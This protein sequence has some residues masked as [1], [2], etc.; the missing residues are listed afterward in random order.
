MRSSPDTGKRGLRSDVTPPAGSSFGRPCPPAVLDRRAL[1]LHEEGALADLPERPRRRWGSSSASVSVR[2]SSSRAWGS[3]SRGC[4]YDLGLGVGEQPFGEAVLAAS[5][6]TGG[7]QVGEAVQD[8]EVLGA[9]GAGELERLLEP[10]A[11]AE[12]GEDAPASSTTTIR[13]VLRSSVSA[14]IIACSQAVAQVIRIPSAAVCVLRTA[15]R[16]STTSGARVE[17]GWSVRR[18][19][20]AGSRCKSWS[21]ANAIGRTT[22]AMST[23]SIASASAI[24]AGGWTSTSTTSGSVGSRPERRASTTIASWPARFSSGVRS[25]ERG[26][27][28]RVEEVELPFGPPRGERVEPD[29]PS[30]SAIG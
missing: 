25:L 26:R 19:C 14:S 3:W 27:G 13:F 12:A 24:S 17:P 4:A 15:R 30:A 11:D 18:T 29:R 23:T 10:F 8:D 7:A 6:G 1:V 20:R 22:F 28:D 5:L 16:L 2:P 9:E 21:S